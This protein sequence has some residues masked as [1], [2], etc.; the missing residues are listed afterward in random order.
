GLGIGA[1]LVIDGRVYRGAGGA[2]GEFGHNFDQRGRQC[3][4][5]RDGCME[6][7]CSDPGLL[8][9]W[10]QRDPTT[11]GKSA[12]DLNAAANSGDS[13][14]RDILRDSGVRLGRHVAA[15]VNI[16]DPEI[17]VFGAEGVRFGDHLFG[18]L[19]EVLAD[20]CY[21]GPPPMA[22]D[23]PGESWPRGA[24]ALAIQHFF[25]FEATGGYRPKQSNSDAKSYALA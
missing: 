9:T 18:P 2:A 20:V 16:V 21:P 17:V 7:Y 19:R 11:N 15:L 24:A 12:D 23:L 10:R 22:I 5:G 14:A 13:I 1:G 6:T 8:E 3:E 25:D 4:C